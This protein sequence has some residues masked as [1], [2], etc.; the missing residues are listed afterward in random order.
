[1][2]STSKYDFLI[3]PDTR[4]EIRHAMFFKIVTTYMAISPLISENDST[5]NLVLG[6]E[7]VPTRLA[8]KCLLAAV[9]DRIGSMQKELRHVTI[10]AA[11][12][13]PCGA[14]DPSRTS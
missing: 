9:Y 14:N 13:T 8:V 1:M 3:V 10:T 4:K 11:A 2:L 7:K 12:D 5:R 6:N